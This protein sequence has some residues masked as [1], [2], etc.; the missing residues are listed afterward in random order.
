MK[1]FLLSILKSAVG[2]AIIQIIIDAFLQALRKK[3]YY[4][5]A[6]EGDARKSVGSQYGNILNSEM[7]RH[8]M[9]TEFIDTELENVKP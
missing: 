6:S 9:I 4:M 7:F 1:K 5:T 8:A 3:G 2:K